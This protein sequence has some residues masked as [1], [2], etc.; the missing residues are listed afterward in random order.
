MSHKSHILG[1]DPDNFQHEK[2]TIDGV[3]YF[4][5]IR[6]ESPSDATNLCEANSDEFNRFYLA[7]IK[8]EREYQRIIDL[9]GKFYFRHYSFCIKKLFLIRSN[10][11]EPLDWNIETE[12]SLYA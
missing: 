5:S 1:S 7:T 4:V 10:A 9:S 11:V 2:Y 6:S 8:N 3:D 12:I